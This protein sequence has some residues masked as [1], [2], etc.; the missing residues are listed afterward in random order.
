MVPSTPSPEPQHPQRKF[1]HPASTAHSPTDSLSHSF[2]KRVNT[3]VSRLDPLLKT[4]QVRPSPPEALI[5]AYLIHVA[6][7]SEPNFRKILDLKGLPRAQHAPLVEIFI[8]H[9]GS[10]SNAALPPSNP[11]LANLSL[12][13][14][15]VGGAAGGAA[16]AG[17]ATPLSGVRDGGAGAAGAGAAGRFDPATFG[18]ALISAAREGVDRFGTPAL[19]GAAARDHSMSPPT[20]G[21]EAAA[22][23][24]NLNDNL[25]S[26]G[27][28]FRRDQGLGFGRFGRG[29]EAAK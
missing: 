23:T 8:A 27:K 15:A 29:G 16:S 18:S 6:D 22:S 1:S 7:R 13:A 26:I 24:G 20:L 3:A 11:L 17:A 2:T 4:L 14:G 12:A 28:F 5:S 9:C 21:A 10:P 25:K 19:G